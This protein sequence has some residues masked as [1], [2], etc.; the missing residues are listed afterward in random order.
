MLPFGVSSNND[1]SNTYILNAIIQYILATKR[2]HVTLTNSWVVWNI[3][4]FENICLRNIEWYLN[5]NWRLYL[6]FIITVL[7]SLVF[8]LLSFFLHQML[9]SWPCHYQTCHFVNI[10][11]LT[12]A[13][14][15]S[16]LVLLTGAFLLT[17]W[18]SL[19]K[20]FLV[21]N[22]GT[23]CL[24]CLVI[25]GFTFKKC[26]CTYIY[27]IIN[28]VVKRRALLSIQQMRYMNNGN[29]NYVYSKIDNTKKKAE[30]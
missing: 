2:F 15:C 1:A 22:P 16:K 12:P 17:L 4:I 9:L 14:I 6:S 28:F 30:I 3:H 27:K 21:E 7:F 11:H 24:T 20:L 29:D 13:S 5:D 25:L 23:K 10:F 18:A 26:I 8:F 19:N